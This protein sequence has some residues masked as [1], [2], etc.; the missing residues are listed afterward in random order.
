MEF[1]A[2]V[3]FFVSPCLLKPRPNDRNILQHHLQAPAERSQNFSTTY[4]NIVEH[5]ISSAFGHCVATSYDILGIE[6]RA[7]A[8]ARVRHCCKK[9]GLKALT[10]ED[11][12]SPTQ[13][14]RCLSAR[15]AFVADTNFVSRT[16]NVSD[17]VQKHFVSA[18][19][20]SQFSQPKKNYGQQC[21]LVYEGLNEYRIM[22]Y[23]QILHEELDHFQICANNTRHVATHRNRVAKRTR[24]VT[25]NN[26]A[27]IW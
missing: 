19:N 10:N 1:A 13:M 15:A 26:I 21:V 20:V 18:T 16:K 17:F 3:L 24:H 4:R 11:T 6:K 14:F 9:S 8:H 23:P 7:S 5:K 27:I 25:P 2:N 12:L 22:Q